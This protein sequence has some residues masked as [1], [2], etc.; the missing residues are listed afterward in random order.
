MAGIYQ[1]KNVGTGNENNNAVVKIKCVSDL[2]TENY[3]SDKSVITFDGRS[4]F[5]E[6]W[7]LNPVTNVKTKGPKRS[8]SQ[9]RATLQIYK[10][11]WIGSP[12]KI[13]LT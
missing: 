6:G 9:E 13:I 7:Y 10:L 12:I 3:M 5:I 1:N 2:I 8:I 4:E 11:F